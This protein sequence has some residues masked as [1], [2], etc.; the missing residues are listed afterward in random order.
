MNTENTSIETATTDASVTTIATVAPTEDIIKRDIMRELPC[1][2]DGE[3]LLDIAIAKSEAEAKLE[4]LQSD[5]SDAKDEWK[6]RL[7][8]VEK[9]IAVMGAE[10]RLKEQK[11]VISCYERFVSGTVE[12]VRA[13]TKEVVERRAANLF[14]ASRSSTRSKSDEE[15]ESAKASADA[16][17]TQRDANVEEDDEGDVVAPEG[18]G[19]RNGKGK[20]K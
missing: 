20:R 18:D 19:K 7:E 16:A 13:D 9:R 1:K 8:E 10:L 14:E 15:A 11:R 6:A 2:L 12:V 4:E 17:K 3:A 5:F